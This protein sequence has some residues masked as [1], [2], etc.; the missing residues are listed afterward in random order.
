MKMVVA[1]VT[2]NGAPSPTRTEAGSG[3]SA[4]KGK[5]VAAGLGLAA[6]EGGRGGAGFPAVAHDERRRA[7]PTTAAHAAEREGR[8]AGRKSLIGEELNRPNPERE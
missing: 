5:G 7:A 2:G 1:D 4:G 8:C 3:T 6:G